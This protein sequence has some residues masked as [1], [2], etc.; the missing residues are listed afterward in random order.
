MSTTRGSNF[1]FEIEEYLKKGLQSEGFDVPEGVIARLLSDLFDG[2]AIH[3]WSR[4]DVFRVA[5]EAGWPISQR[6][7]DT[8]LSNIES[9]VDPEYGITWL[10]LESAVQDFY[11][12]LDWGTV[13]PEEREQC[14]GDFLLVRSVPLD[15]NPAVH[16]E[17]VTLASVLE[18]AS[19]L[20]A[21][22]RAT[23]SVYGIPKET[24]PSLEE[25]WL[26][27]LAHKLWTF[28]IREP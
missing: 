11:E 10:T 28:S 21:A 7:A 20:A 18:T 3:V 26:K 15:E 2:V 14:I 27:A 6:M 12:K 5:W 22:D 19:K 9:H 16:L 24:A 1:Y 23:V 17:N 13:E 8:I 4:P 25:E